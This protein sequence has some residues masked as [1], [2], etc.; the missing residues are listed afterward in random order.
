MADIAPIR[1]FED[2]EALAWLKT[3]PGG[4]INLP[5]AELGQRFGWTPQRTGRRLKAWKKAR[6]ITKR[7]NTVMVA[8]EARQ[9]AAFKDVVVDRQ[10]LD[11]ASEILGSVT[12]SKAA[13]IIPS[14]TPSTGVDIAAYIAAIGL[15]S[16]AALFSIKGM[17][18]LF[19]GWPAAVGALACMMESAKLVTAGWL[20]RRWRS[21]AWIWRGVLVVLVAGLAVI[22]GVGVFSQLVAAHVGERGA[23]QSAIETQDAALMA[24]ID[25]QAHAVADLDRRLN[26]VDL[27][28][29]EAAKRGKTNTALSAIEAQKKRREALVDERKRE[30]GALAALRTERASVVARGRQI[31]TEAAPIRYVAELLGASADSERAIRWLIAL[32]ESAHPNDWSER[33]W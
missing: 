17:V 30:A 16:V 12:P 11:R 13:P 5:P 29:E 23:T 20:A 3:Q 9:K 1:T 32:R 18:Q 27:A 22:N 15:A 19:P 28:I 31:E 6:L 33:K 7:G 8:T 21:T 25:V 24:R 2:E 4:R 10:H 14:V 26:Q